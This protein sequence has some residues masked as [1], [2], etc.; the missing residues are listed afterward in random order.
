MKAGWNN[1]VIDLSANSDWTGVS[2]VVGLRIDPVAVNTNVSLKLDWV[3]LTPKATQTVPISWTEANLATPL[4]FYAGKTCA[5]SDALLLNILSN[6][7]D[8][9]TW[10]WGESW[11]SDTT[12]ESQ[13]FYP[14]P[15]SLEPGTYQLFTLSNNEGTPNCTSLEIEADGILDFAK[16]SMRSG[17]EYSFE[18]LGNAWDFS[19]SADVQSTVQITGISFDN[20]IFSGT[21]VAMPFMQADPVVNLNY[22]NS[23]LINTIKYKYFTVRMKLDGNQDVGGGWVA[24]VLWWHSAPT[25][26]TFG[27]TQDIVLYEGWQ[28]YT[29]DLSQAAM[30]QGPTW[31]GTKNQIRF[32]P[33]ESWNPLKFYID[34]IQL[35]GDE[36]I[37]PGQKFT[38]VYN[39]TNA[40]TVT[41][42]YD[43]DRDPGSGQVAMQEY[44]A[45]TP[46]AGITDLFLPLITLG[47]REI[48]AGNQYVW[49]T[50][51]VNPGVYYVCAAVDNGVSTTRWCSET[52]VYIDG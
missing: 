2:K 45:P 35:R 50:Q 6:P 39:A 9:G 30:A 8:E 42:Y 34:D 13:A 29:F 40:Q 4:Y 10:N 11:L 33:H 3:R 5:Q 25:A 49:D 17:P 51:N 32:D 28:E 7:T 19:S 22:S 1:L 26:A 37:K 38:V 16:P 15:A 43:T 18:T 44:V 12:H 41:F 36:H 23:A 47:G 46:V 48:P 20:G 52:P 31:T 24:R 27:I 21:S 14:V